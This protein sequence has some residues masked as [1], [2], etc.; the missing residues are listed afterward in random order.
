LLDFLFERQLKQLRSTSGAGIEVAGELNRPRPTE[1]VSHAQPV[2]V[3]PGS[4]RQVQLQ[5]EG[6]RSF[7]I[8]EVAAF[9]AGGNIPPNVQSEVN[10]TYAVPEGSGS[11]PSWIQPPPLQDSNWQAA[12]TGLSL[13]DNRGAVVNSVY[14]RQQPISQA[15]PLLAQDS[16]R[17]S[18]PSCLAY[19]QLAQAT[20]PSGL[21]YPQLAQATSP[22]S[23]AYPQLA[24]AISPSSLAYPQLAQGLARG[25][26][27]SC[28]AYPHL[29]Q[30]VSRDACL[31]IYSA[32]NSSIAGRQTTS[33]SDVFGRNT[34]KDLLGI[35]E[36]QQSFLGKGLYLPV[37]FCLHV[38]GSRSDE[39]ELLSTPSGSKL[40]WT[41]NSNKK[42]T[43]EK[44]SH[45]L[46]LGAN[47][48]ILAR[49]VPNL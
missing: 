16:A 36:Y 27:P 2:A 35:N 21:A 39:E 44:L 4:S 47:A 30:G 28:L 24:Q 15:Y 48:R 40:V 1:E 22:P 10:R 14:N 9:I 41:S 5:P 38:R 49:I 46:F 37:N 8:E 3:T 31:P 20:S 13:S 43:P 11:Q 7:S 45:G 12:F 34:L 19:P 25:S 26:S 33:G 18:S 32:Q 6:K 29:A 17:V 42:I 23:L